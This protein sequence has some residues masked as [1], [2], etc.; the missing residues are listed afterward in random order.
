MDFADLHQR[1][2]AMQENNM[3]IIKHQEVENALRSAFTSYTSVLADHLSCD[4]YFR[5]GSVEY[6][7][8]SI[9]KSNTDWA[10]NSYVVHWWT[11]NHRDGSNGVDSNTQGSAKLVQNKEGVVDYIRAQLLLYDLPT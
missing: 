9:K 2:E 3:M 7:W 6:V 11:R 4:I 1:Q 10:S 8:V 5:E